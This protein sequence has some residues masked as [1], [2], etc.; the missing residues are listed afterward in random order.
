MIRNAAS[1][2]WKLRTVKGSEVSRCFASS[3]SNSSSIL[4]EESYPPPRSSFPTAKR[5]KSSPQDDASFV[6]SIPSSVSTFGAPPKLLSQYT[7]LPPTPLSLKA[8]LALSPSASSPPPQSQVHESALFTSR[9]LPIRLARRVA[10]FRALP[11]I[12]GA[13]PHIGRV[14]RLYAES[15]EILASWRDLLDKGGQGEE[16]RFV[17]S[18]RELV[19]RHRDN[20]PTL[21]RGE[22]AVLVTVM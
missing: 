17:D 7:S 6:P 19:E 12:V 13:N 15:F 18:L 11:F 3:S 5:R 21:A 9:E 22:S 8:L 1:R 20:V 14:A 2:A 16:E 10:A 4:E